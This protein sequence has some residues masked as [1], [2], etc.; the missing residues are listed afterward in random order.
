M[1]PSQNSYEPAVLIPFRIRE[2]AEEQR[3]E[4]VRPVDTDR[5]SVEVYERK[6]GTKVVFFRGRP[7]AGLALSERQKVPVEEISDLYKRR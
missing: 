6:T 1:A 4:I 3:I 5:Q 2:I 7:K